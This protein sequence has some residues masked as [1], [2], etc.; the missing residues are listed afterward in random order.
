VFKKTYKENQPIGNIITLMEK[1][2]L[3]MR[4][5]RG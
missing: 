5:N 1:I 3:K 2:R 4:Y